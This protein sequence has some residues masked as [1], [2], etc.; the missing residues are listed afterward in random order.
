MDGEAASWKQDI[1][2]TVKATI[3]F[4]FQIRR[5]SIDKQAVDRMSPICDRIGVEGNGRY[6]PDRQ[7]VSSRNSDSTL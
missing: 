3:D 2:G 4:A 6:R 1:I 5:F 7:F